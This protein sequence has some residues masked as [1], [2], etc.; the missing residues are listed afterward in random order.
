MV[1][2]D[3]DRREAFNEQKRRRIHRGLDWL[4]L[5]VNPYPQPSILTIPDA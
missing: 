2:I 4:I 3:G 5:N 1:A